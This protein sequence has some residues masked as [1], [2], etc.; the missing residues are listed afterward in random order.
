M[1]IELNV[2][3]ACCLVESTSTHSCVVEAIDDG[4]V[5]QPGC[6]VRKEALCVK[7]NTLNGLFSNGFLLGA[8]PRYWHCFDHTFSFK[9]K[10]KVYSQC[11]YARALELNT[12]SKYLMTNNTDAIYTVKS[13]GLDGIPLELWKSNEFKMHM[14]DFCNMAYSIR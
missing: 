9:Y 5:H 11:T 8:F 2:P 10:I 4:L 3:L 13:V 6:V 7:K 1:C 12:I 14:P